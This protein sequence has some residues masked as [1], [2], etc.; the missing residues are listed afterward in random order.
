MSYLKVKLVISACCLAS[1]LGEE[2]D[3]LESTKNKEVSKEAFTAS[4]KDD[5]LRH[6]RQSFPFSSFQPFAPSQTSDPGLTEG[7]SFQ[8]IRM[9][10]EET[11]TSAQNNPLRSRSSQG[12]SDSARPRLTLNDLDFNGFEFSKPFSSSPLKSAVVDPSRF[13]TFSTP[14][15]PSRL[16]NAQPTIPSNQLTQF[17][18]FQQAQV[19]TQAPR[20]RF[21]NF[22]LPP[23]RDPRRRNRVQPKV[24][25][26]AP[27]FLSTQTT[28]FPE[29]N[30]FQRAPGQNSVL[31]TFNNKR[32]RQRF[33]TVAR[34]PTTRAP[35]TRTTVS[36]IPTTTAQTFAL[37]PQSSVQESSRSFQKQKSFNDD[38]EEKDAL[39]DN[40]LKEAIKHSREIEELENRTALHIEYAQEKQLE[41][42]HLEETLETLKN[43][44][45]LESKK[46]S[47]LE[48]RIQNLTTLLET[49]D[50]SI[51][52]LKDDITKLEDTFQKEELKKHE[53]I[54][55]LNEKLEAT[56]IELAN[57][58]ISL[59]NKIKE[60]ERRGA[61]LKEALAKIDKFKKEKKNLLK[62]VQQLA[63]IGNPSLNFNTF[64]IVAENQ[65]LGDYKDYGEVDEY[66]YD[67][68]LNTLENE[69]FAVDTFEPEGSGALA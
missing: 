39:I 52:K 7:F 22:N 33:R 58:K 62:I 15:E 63:E 8:R 26:E 23:N 37:Q 40:C 17:P 6:A 36:R 13:Q 24:V 47:N 57:T 29:S 9:G 12:V 27:R 31:N 53:T 42:Q 19:V 35:V 69:Y 50:T 46:L 45:K 56:T 48:N 2:K 43:E 30:N 65:E 51:S 66:D 38:T 5:K 20:S 34:I 28:T 55:D 25:N 21:T 1:I 54:Q 68:E 49:K 67:H 10:P 44:S 32:M 16:R 4:E 41:I 64:S 14:T 60:D 59:N 11:Q 18:N 3:F 61:E